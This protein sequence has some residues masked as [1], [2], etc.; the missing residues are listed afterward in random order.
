MQPSAARPRLD[1]QVAACPTQAG[2]HAGNADAGPEG[3][4]WLAFGAAIGDFAYIADQLV[5]PV[6][7]TFDC[8][9]H[10]GCGSVTMLVSLGLLLLAQQSS[11]HRIWQRLGLG[12]DS[13]PGVELGSS[14]EAI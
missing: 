1:R 3:R 12:A 14:A 7:H 11:L 2:R 5:N 6:G 4:A 8:H 10:L 13:E 9:G